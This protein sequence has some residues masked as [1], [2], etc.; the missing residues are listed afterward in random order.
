MNCASKGNVVITQNV[1]ISAD[2]T[3]QNLI[4]LCN[5]N[6]RCIIQPGVTVSMNANLNVGVL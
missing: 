1:T 3:A 5:A 6:T 2:T 4:S